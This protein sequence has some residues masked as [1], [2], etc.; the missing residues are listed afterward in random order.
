MKEDLRKLKDKKI[1]EDIWW[2][3]NWNSDTLLKADSLFEMNHILDALIEELYQKY[4]SLNEEALLVKL[5]ETVYALMKVEPDML[6]NENEGGLYDY[7][8]LNAF[9]LSIVACFPF[10][11]KEKYMNDTDMLYDCIYNRRM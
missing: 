1:Y 11:V 8:G 4:D 5:Q 2:K 10:Y 7:G 9:F 3:Y 6:A